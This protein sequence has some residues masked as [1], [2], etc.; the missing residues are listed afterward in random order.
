MAALINLTTKL[1]AKAPHLVGTPDDWCRFFATA[2]VDPIVAVTHAVDFL[3]AALA[4]T[5]LLARVVRRRTLNP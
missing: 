5:H 3:T 2:H 1:I 4:A